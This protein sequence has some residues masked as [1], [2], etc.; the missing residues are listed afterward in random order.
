MITIKQIAPD[1]Y[2]VNGKLVHK[3]MDGNWI[4]NPEMTTKEVSAF[5]SHIIN[6]Q[7]AAHDTASR[8]SGKTT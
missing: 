2:S 4:G 6:I 1:R 5:Q 8:R 3:D 7:K